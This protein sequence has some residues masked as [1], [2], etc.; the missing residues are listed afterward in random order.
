MQIGLRPEQEKPGEGE[1]GWPTKA[2]LI[3][4]KNQVQEGVLPLVEYE[5]VERYLE[6][7]GRQDDL[8][9]VVVAVFPPSR[10]S[11]ASTF[12]EPL[13]PLPL[14][15]V[16]RELARHKKHSLGIVVNRQS[17]SRMTGET[18]RTTT[19]ARAVCGSGGIQ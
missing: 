8:N 16:E 7:I 17:P 9:D 15:A 13:H 19:T 11:P 3:M 2:D 18:S 4:P 10:I 14:G 5:Q 12:R 6:L 1:A